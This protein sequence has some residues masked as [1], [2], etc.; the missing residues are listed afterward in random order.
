M[1]VYSISEIIRPCN[2]DQFV[3]NIIYVWEDNKFSKH[4]IQQSREPTPTIPSTA[5][6]STSAVILEPS[7]NKSQSNKK[8]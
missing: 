2:D 7:T 3:L 8:T 5:V 4:N 1:E 6:S